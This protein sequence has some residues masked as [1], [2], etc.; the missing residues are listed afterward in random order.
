[1]KEY[2][3]TRDAPLPVVLED[4]EA[5]DVQQADDGVMFAR[6]VL[7]EDHNK[8][9]HVSFTEKTLKKNP[10]LRFNENVSCPGFCDEENVCDC[11]LT[12]F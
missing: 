5:V 12:R 1:M 7:L 2:Q 3:K 4:L 8:N 9:T 6:V 11:L 10:D